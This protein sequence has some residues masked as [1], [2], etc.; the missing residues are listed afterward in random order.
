MRTLKITAGLA[1]EL[2]VL[3]WYVVHRRNSIRS[4][5]IQQEHFDEPRLGHAW[6]RYQQDESLGL[7]DLGLGGSLADDVIDHPCPRSESAARKSESRM[8]EEWGKRAVLDAAAKTIERYASDPAVK[9]SEITEYLREE[10]AVADSGQLRRSE[11]ASVVRG[12]V[13][14]N[15]IDRWDGKRQSR[16]V[17]MGVPAMQQYIGGWMRGKLHFWIAPTSGHKT[18]FARTHASHAGRH[19]FDVVYYT[20]EDEPEDIEARS[21]VDEDESMTTRHI[22][23]DM[24]PDE[25]AVERLTAAKGNAPKAL[26]YGRCGRVTFPQLCSMVRAEAPRGLSAVVIDHVHMLRPQRRADFDFWCNVGDGLA[27]L[28]KELDIAIIGT[29]QMDKQSS[30]DYESGRSPTMSNVRY[31]GA[32][33]NPARSVYVTHWVRAPKKEPDS[34]VEFQIQSAERDNKR[35]LKV[36]CEKNTNGPRGSWLLICDPAHDRIEREIRA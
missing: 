23:G 30:V 27:G 2:D 4:A 12:R 22:H 13:V 20:L 16:Y 5:S 10:I 17:P 19:G 15:T 28:A 35:V 11:E 34:D 36:V 26:R 8:I 21:L 33:T 25:T 1:A 3:A 7:H 32:L 18:T 31:G 29:A 14:D 6:A 9:L 24:T